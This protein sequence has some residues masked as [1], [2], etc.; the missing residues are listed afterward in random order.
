MNVLI[1]EDNPN[2]RRLLRYTFEHHGCSVVEAENGREGL[3]LA[4]AHRP[5]IIVSDALMPVMDGFQLLRALKSNQE[6]RSIPFVFYSATYTEQ[7]ETEL[8]LSQGAEA[9]I[10]KPKAPEEVW[11]D[12]CRI[13]RA[14]K[15]RQGTPAH[16]AT[17]ESEEQYLREYSQ[18]VATKLEKKVLELEE[19]LTRRSQAEEEVRKLNADL[20]ER[21]RERTAELERRTRELEESRQALVNLVEDLNRT[22]SELQLA[23][24]TLTT[25]IRQRQE[26]QEEISGLN[27]NLLRQ[28][29]ALEESNR[30]LEAFSYSISHDL[31]APLRHI[32]GFSEV[33]QAEYASE[34]PPAGQDYLERIRKA[35]HHTQRLTDDL[36]TYSRL[37]RSPLHLEQ[38]NL[39][40]M[41]RE[42]IGE[43]CQSEPA[44][45]VE[46]VISEGVTASGDA[47]LLRAVMENLLGNAW[48]YTGKKERAVIAF[49]AEERDNRQVY[50][51]RDNGAGFDMAYSSRLFGVFQRLH[52]AEE[53]DGTGVGLATCQRIIHRHGGEIWAEAEPGK[54]A[55]FYFTL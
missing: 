8:A 7:N 42:I 37:I 48:K 15:A 35:C 21:V 27:E 28:K 30:E 50:F 44:R 40:D 41:S 4:S 11:L 38:I 55:T 47:T 36:L 52:K 5:D 31:R 54:G 17:K 43:M 51:V 23:N 14:S 46:T 19:A 6:L 29:H 53:F 22:A 10:I 34:L 49:G 39:S 20:E 25:E 12:T 45:Q 13:Y 9:F 16:E 26:A 24:E 32:D 1:V 33:L 3:E 2:D 18:I